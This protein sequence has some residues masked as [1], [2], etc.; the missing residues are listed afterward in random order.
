MR[1]TVTGQRFEILYAV[2]GQRLITSV[3]GKEAAPGEMFAAL[4]GGARQYQIS[5][6][7]ITTTL[8]GTPFQVT[9]YKVGERYVAARNNEF[10]YANYE[11]VAVKQ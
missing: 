6:G 7:Q 4:H 9:V 8:G 11:I 5:N 2:D 3:D 1:N 10:G